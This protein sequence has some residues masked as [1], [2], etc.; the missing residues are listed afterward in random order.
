MYLP[1]SSFCTVKELLFKGAFD[2]LEGFVTTDHDSEVTMELGNGRFGDE[3]VFW[4]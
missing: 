4:K 1:K 2:F 3:K